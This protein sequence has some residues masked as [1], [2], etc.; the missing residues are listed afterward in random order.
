TLWFGLLCVVIAFRVLL[1]GERFLHTIIP[2]SYWELLL[3]VEYL[4]MNLGVIFFLLFLQFLFP[5]EMPRRA[6]KILFVLTAILMLPILIFPTRVFSRLLVGYEVVILYSVILCIVTLTTAIIRKRPG[7]FVIALSSFF[8]AFSVVN[9]VLYSQKLIFTFQMTGLG[10]FIF[11]FSQSFILSMKFSKAFSTNEI[12]SENLTRYNIA[13]ERFVPREFL[14]YLAKDSILDIE[15][16]DQVQ[17]DMTIVFIDIRSFTA[18]SEKMTPKENF[19]FLNNYLGRVSPIIRK[20]NGFIDKYLGDG[21]MALF[22][23]R[24]EDAVLAV[25]EIQTAVQELNDEIR[26]K[27][28]PQIT[29]GAG[30]HTGRL[31]LGIVGE[32]ER[33]DGTVISDAV[34]LASRVEGLNKRFGSTLVISE[35]TLFQL[36]DPTRFSFRFLGRVYVQGKSAPV[37]IFEFYDADPK[38]VRIVKTVT[39]TEF[40]K[41]VTAY[42]EEQ[43][44]DAHN[45]FQ[46]ILRANPTDRA[47]I[48]YLRILTE[49]KIA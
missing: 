37:S 15:L 4:S 38:D 11:I 42:Y 23:K 2:Y 5:F 30:I 17:A 18:L 29:I 9:D 21:F 39:R 12:L 25:L 10:L 49:K 41:G 22:P 43:L 48:E 46:S 32:K 8:L 35:D 28:L 3:K 14:Q 7:A 24:A 31:M 45:I 36:D 16:G 1:M 34:N 40:E 33:M 26:D 13:Y 6:L 47:V 44:D 27:N 19:N 20:Y